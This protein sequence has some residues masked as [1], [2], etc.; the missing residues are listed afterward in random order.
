MIEQLTL[1]EKYFKM[2]ADSIMSEAEEILKMIRYKKSKK[3]VRK[4]Y[5]RIQNR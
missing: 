3:M 2:V 5:R 4:L 1:E